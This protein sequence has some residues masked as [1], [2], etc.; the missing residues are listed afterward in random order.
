M[1][2]CHY[3]YEKI[4]G[5]LPPPITLAVKYP[6]LQ[7]FTNYPDILFSD[8]IIAKEFDDTTCEYCPLQHTTLCHYYECTGVYCWDPMCSKMENKYAALALH[9]RQ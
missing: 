3:V 6:I 7:Q 2:H 4:P 9:I 8:C 5:M 1:N